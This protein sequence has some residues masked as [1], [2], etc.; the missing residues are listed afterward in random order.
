MV[1]KIGL[2]V[3]KILEKNNIKVVYTRK[4]DRTIL[5]SNEKQDLKKRVQIS[6]ESNANVFVSI[7]CNRY[8]DSSVKG[9]E[10]WC[11]EPNSKD[12][13][14]AKKILDKL[15]NLKYTVKRSIKNRNTSSLYVLKNNKATSVLVE[16][17][18][19]SNKD[20]AKFITSNEGQNKCANAIAEA[21]LDFKEGT[22]KSSN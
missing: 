17:G 19:L 11:N 18:Y 15:Y 13:E 9:I 7:H 12:E 16:I 22:T 4:N 3:G 20:D 1:L 21:I 10:L 5:G 6:N 2:K 14:L 8:K